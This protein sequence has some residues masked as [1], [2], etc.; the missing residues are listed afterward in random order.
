MTEQ[1]R[2]GIR[3]RRSARR[4]QGPPAESPAES[5]PDPP[6][7]GDQSEAGRLRKRQR[8]RSPAS[9]M[10]VESGP[11]APAPSRDRRADA[12]ERALR[13]LVTTRGTQVGWSAATRA[14][15]VAAPTEADLAE[16]AAELVIVRR[17]YTPTEPLRNSRTDD[18]AARL[19][20]PR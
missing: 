17:N 9:P 12:S 14:R 20:R 7:Q 13:G 8:K 15:S 3:R 11:P 16:A 1:P 5:I 10:P 19:R 18:V 4:D 6:D 2:P